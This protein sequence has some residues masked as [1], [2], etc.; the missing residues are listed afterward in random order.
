[1]KLMY[2]FFRESTQKTE[3]YWY[4]SEFNACTKTCGRA[5]KSRRVLCI[6]FTHMTLLDDSKC[7]K[8][9]RPSDYVLCNNPECPVDA[10]W[11]IGTWSKVKI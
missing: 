4:K 9:E 10:D 7:S 3:G 1:M 6:G 8:N 2:F 5:I 11:V